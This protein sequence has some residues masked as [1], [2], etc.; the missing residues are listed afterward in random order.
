M[1]V[2]N[3][4][5]SSTT[6]HTGRRGHGAR[7]VQCVARHGTH[8]PQQAHTPHNGTYDREVPFCS[9]AFTSAVRSS[10]R[11]PYHMG[12]CSEPPPP[13]PPSADPT[14]GPRDRKPS[15]SRASGDDTC[16]MF[17]LALFALARLSY[18]ARMWC[19]MSDALSFLVGNPG[20]RSG[21]RVGVVGHNAAWGRGWCLTDDFPSKTRGRV[22]DDTRATTATAGALST[23]KRPPLTYTYTSTSTSTTTTSTSPD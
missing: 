5:A 2:C 22:N 20:R 21:K 16:A 11:R 12:W 18:A 9:S 13:P 4:R 8:G 19:T 3:W 23:L 6:R 10:V 7:L 17:V 1:Y 15:L 14:L